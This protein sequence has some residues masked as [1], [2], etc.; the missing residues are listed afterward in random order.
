MHKITLPDASKMR[1]KTFIY[2][3]ATSSFQ[4]EGA[5]DRRLP[6]IWDRFCDTPNKIKDASNGLVACEHID[7]WLEDVEL[8]ASL[9]VDAYRFSISWPRVMNR[10]GSLNEQGLAFYKRLIDELNARNIKSFVTFYHWDLPQHLEDKG[11]WL[12]RDTAF[13]F[14]DYVSLVSS[15]LGESVYAYATL[16]EPFCSAYLGYETGLHAPGITG[17]AN[18]RKAAHHLLLAHGLA[19]RG[20]R[21]NAPA[22]L[23]GIV[24]NFSPCYPASDSKQ[25]KQAADTAEQY[26][27]AW[28]LEP[29]LE[30]RY[31]DV[32]EQL[33]PD[34]RPDIQPG[35][36]ATIAQPLDYLGINFYTR[37]VIKA[38]QDGWFEESVPDNVA[39]TDMG[40]EIYPQ[41]LTE[42][43]TSYHAQYSLPPLYITENGAA[44]ADS[45]ENGE[46]KDSG[47]IDYFQQHL[48][49]V[50]DAIAQ[51]VDVRGYFAWSLMDN[52]EWAEGYLKRFGI[53]YVDYATQKRTL[54]NSAKAYRDLVRSR[55]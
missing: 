45:M 37:A 5:A 10:D 35:D 41:S 6:C 48:S 7:R 16:N 21:K 14:R 24:L 27:N 55:V 30:G 43:L 40:W 36:M 11:G 46:V 34:E 1:A 54:K 4:I 23:S 33:T 52:F 17:R 42:L 51:G 47:R 50:H 39:V 25:D 29:V 49:A 38:T 53:V 15:E 9:G 20:R 26:M 19:M 8:I 31:P 13:L 44:M 12:S 2:G 18:G 22:S 32:I 28:Y 3:V